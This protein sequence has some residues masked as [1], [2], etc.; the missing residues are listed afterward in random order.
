MGN[1]EELIKIKF[2]VD[3]EKEFYSFDGVRVF[4]EE[5]NDDVLGG[6]GGGDDIDVNMF[7]KELLNRRNIGE[8]KLG[9]EED[10]FDD[11]EIEKLFKEGGY[12]NGEIG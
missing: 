1:D 8:R 3:V 6:G 4:G 10:F 5:R 9:S 2:L 12:G 11:F 7:L